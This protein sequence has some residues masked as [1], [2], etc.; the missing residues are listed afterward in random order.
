MVILYQMTLVQ[1]ILTFNMAALS[2]TYQPKTC[3]SYMGLY[4]GPGVFYGSSL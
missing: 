3:L 1:K 2:I 4:Q